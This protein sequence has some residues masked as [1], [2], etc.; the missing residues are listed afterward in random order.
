MGDTEIGE[1]SA[2]KEAFQGVKTAV[3][4]NFV[5]LKITDTG[6]FTSPW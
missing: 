1:E 5:A 6:K 4:L 2:K 3:P